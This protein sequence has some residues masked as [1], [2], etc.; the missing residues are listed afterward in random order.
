[1]HL[2]W[3]FCLWVCLEIFWR[4][5]K[6]KIFLTV[7]IR[8]C[9]RCMSPH[10]L[11]RMAAKWDFGASVP[12]ISMGQLMLRKTTLFLGILSFLKLVHDCTHSLAHG[13]YLIAFMW[14]WLSAWTRQAWCDSTI[15]FCSLWWVVMNP[16]Y[17]LADLQ[18]PL[19]DWQNSSSWVHHWLSASVPNAHAVFPNS[20]T[21]L[22]VCT[23]LSLHL[24]WNQLLSEQIG[25]C[26]T[27][28]RSSCYKDLLTLSFS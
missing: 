4:K 7:K 21:V 14:Q 1:M 17:L 3:I 9:F 24:S 5:K 2:S 12:Y 26:R 25:E 20:D 8:S 15:N 10:Q 27:P 23:I 18:L 19:H 11:Q 13:W 16:S 28:I 6:K 22:P